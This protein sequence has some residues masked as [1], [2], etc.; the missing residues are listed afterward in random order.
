M[1][2][3]DTEMKLPLLLELERAGG[4]A[5]LQQ[6]TESVKVHFPNLTAADLAITNRDG[7][8]P[9]WQNR[10]AFARQYLVETGDIDGS[11]HGRW[12]ITE[13]GKRH[14]RDRLRAL[15]ASDTES[16]IRSQRSLGEIAEP[17]QWNWLERQKRPPKARPAY[18]LSVVQ[19]SASVQSAAPTQPQR[20]GA[21]PLAERSLGQL[22]ADHLAGL[23]TEL[24][25]RMSNLSADQFEELVADLLRRLGYTDVRRTGGP[26]DRNIDVTAAHMPPFIRVAV[27]VQVKHRRGG[28]N[29]GPTDVAAFR[30]RAGGADHTLL[31]VTNVEFTDGAKETASEQGRQLVHLADGKHLI[32]AMAENRIGIKEGPMGVLEIDEEFW[33]QF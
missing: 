2:P 8:T 20:A 18:A 3:R 12:R 23:R 17:A 9:K 25:H 21:P 22:I 24:A 27:R 1:L 5:G 16:F 14:L 15:N 32:D 13:D 4:V 26:G 7:R 6:M 19:R 33:G 10:L 11:V 28:P 29:I 31:M 30:D